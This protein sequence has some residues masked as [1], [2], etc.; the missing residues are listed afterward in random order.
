[1][2]V[3]GQ[4]TRLVEAT[5]LTPL[6][7]QA[8]I[9]PLNGTALVTKNRVG[10]MAPAAINRSRLPHG[11]RGKQELDRRTLSQSDVVGGSFGR[12]LF[13][14]DVRLVVAIAKKFPGRP[15]ASH[16]VARGSHAAGPLPRSDRSPVQSLAR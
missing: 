10:C 6:C 14:D 15:V 5:Y 13:A 3:L 1:M 4:S 8:P 12:R 7:D 16:L 11:R 2:K 9:E